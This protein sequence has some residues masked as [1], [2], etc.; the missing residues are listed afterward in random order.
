MITSGHTSYHSSV[1]GVPSMRVLRTPSRTY[2][3]GEK[4]A[5]TC[6]QG[7]RISML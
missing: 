5:S 6:I 2:V 1:I 3:A 4:C 7:G